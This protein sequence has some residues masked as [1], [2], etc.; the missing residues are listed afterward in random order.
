MKK[1]L[2]FTLFLA[3]FCANA[4]NDVLFSDDFSDNKNKWTISTTKD[5]ERNIKDGKLVLNG[6]VT[7]KVFS[8]QKVNT[9]FYTFL[10]EN[11]RISKSGH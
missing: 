1:L 10:Q 2:L 9:K 3:H 4:Q 7:G 5:T 8:L 11:G 6:L